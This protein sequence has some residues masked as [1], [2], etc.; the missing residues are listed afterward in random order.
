[1]VSDSAKTTKNYLIV[2]GTFF[3]FRGASHIRD[4]SKIGNIWNPAAAMVSKGDELAALAIISLT[5]RRIY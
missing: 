4:Q 5:S 2:M 1:M 3:A